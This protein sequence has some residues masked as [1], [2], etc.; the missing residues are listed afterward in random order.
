MCG[1]LCKIVVVVGQRVETWF[2]PV[3]CM[4]FTLS[5]GLENL[6]CQLQERYLTSQDH[7]REMLSYAWLMKRFGIIT[8]SSGP[9][10]FWIISR[11][12]I[13]QICR[14][15]FWR[16]P[17]QFFY[18]FWYMI[19][20][21]DVILRHQLRPGG[22]ARD[23][24]MGFPLDTARR[25]GFPDRKEMALNMGYSMQFIAILILV[26]IMMM[27]TMMTM[28]MMMVMLVMLVMV[29]V[30]VMMM[31]M[32]MVMMMMMMMKMNEQMY[33]RA[34]YVQ[35]NWFGLGTQVIYKSV[36]IQ[37]LLYCLVENG[38]PLMT[39][40]LTSTYYNLLFS[41]TNRGFNMFQY[42]K[43]VKFP[44]FFCGLRIAHSSESIALLSLEDAPKK[45]AAAAA[46]AE[47]EDFGIQGGFDSRG[48][49][50]TVIVAKL[51]SC[52]VSKTMP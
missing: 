25:I 5:H 15:M 47:F 41:S 27:M 13:W 24:S 50:K 19:I 52:N 36:K 29:M 14:H 44:M 42:C 8:K 17:C 43:N 51:S 30:M 48:H 16:K 3:R 37:I 12:T 10:E 34:H 4:W 23:P 28:T 2:S 49:M 20:L 38:V 9:H 26:G 35:T 11:Q 6:G 40:I 7:F 39:M 45:K 21:S 33:L 46:S 22:V 32:I 18:I 1:F 31:M